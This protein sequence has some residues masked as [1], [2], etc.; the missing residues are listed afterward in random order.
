MT[1]VPFLSA[2]STDRNFRFD[3]PGKTPDVVFCDGKCSN[4]EPLDTDS[5]GGKW[6]YDETAKS[7]GFDPKTAR[8]N[9]EQDAKVQSRLAD[10]IDALL[11]DV[12]AG[13]GI[14]SQHGDFSRHLGSVSRAA[15]EAQTAGLQREQLNRLASM[16]GASILGTAERRAAV[17]TVINA[18]MKV[19]SAKPEMKAAA[20]G[21]ML[22][23]TVGALAY[24]DRPLADQPLT[25]RTEPATKPAPQ[26]EPER[27]PLTPAAIALDIDQD[28]KLQCKELG[29]FQPDP[30]YASYSRNVQ[31][32][33][34]KITG[35]PGQD[36]VIKGEATRP[37]G[38]KD[39]AIQQRPVITEAKADQGEPLRTPKEWGEDA[40]IRIRDQGKKQAD[41]ADKYGVGIEW[42]V[43]TEVDTGIIRGLFEKGGIETPVINTPMPK[44][45]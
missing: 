43:Q 33:Q 10:T 15:D 2:G 35:H 39:D 20:E 25:A 41:L 32:Y 6:M 40:K 44:V 18:E 21:A 26:N 42:H 12:K 14:A 38:C 7:F 23:G 22:I 36:F 34:D 19:L 11:S 31:A 16:P 45:K 4:S 9:P 30:G 1:T 13:K 27:P 29:M 37:D 5:G 24:S 28:G 17:Q 3:L 8:Q